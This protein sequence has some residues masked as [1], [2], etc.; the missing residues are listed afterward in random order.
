M[1]HM[2]EA[3]AQGQLC[4]KLSN[5]LAAL[6]IVGF[7]CST[8]RA[9]IRSKSS[10]VGFVRKAALHLTMLDNPAETPIYRLRT[11]QDQKHN[12]PQQTL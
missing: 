11:N 9:A 10:R 12:R 6:A 8:G 3:H 7:T 2:R 5:Y 1:K 4:Q